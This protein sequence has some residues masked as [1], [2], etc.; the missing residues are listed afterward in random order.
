[1]L[2]RKIK[3][4]VVLVSFFLLL[5]TFG[6]NGKHCIKLGGEYQGAKGDLEYCYD[7]QETKDVGV[8]VL[9][10]KEGK[11]NYILDDKQVKALANSKAFT[12]AMSASRKEVTQENARDILKR[13]IK[14]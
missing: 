13:I 4:S 5:V 3:I 7:K 10:D 14:K 8:P 12:S 1:M 11:A 2:S 9:K 6:C